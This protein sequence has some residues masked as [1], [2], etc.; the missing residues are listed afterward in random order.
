MSRYLTT[1]HQREDKIGESNG[2]LLKVHLTY[3]HVSID[4]TDV[5]VT[6][7]TT[8]NNSSKHNRKR[9]FVVLATV[10]EDLR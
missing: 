9:Q 3:G 8:D 5:E 10:I 1:V 4:I 7:K 6:I 2:I